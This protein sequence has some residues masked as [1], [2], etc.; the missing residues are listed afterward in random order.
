MFLN[1]HLTSVATAELLR[2]GIAIS[3]L[4]CRVSDR[5]NGTRFSFCGHLSIRRGCLP[6]LSSSASL[7]TFYVQSCNSRRTRSAVVR[8]QTGY[9]TSVS[10]SREHLIIAKMHARGLHNV[11]ADI[12]DIL[13]RRP[14]L[15]FSAPFRRAS[16]HSTITAESRDEKK[17]E[18]M[19]ES[20]GTPQHIVLDYI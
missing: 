9:R 17:R 6:R 19:N 8:E 13:A 10:L 20:S 16:W 14:L 15:S 5:H 12:K 4:S 11:F 3:I 7:A 18:K 2:C 1:D